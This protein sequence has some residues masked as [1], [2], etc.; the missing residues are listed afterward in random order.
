MGG[1]ESWFIRLLSTAQKVASITT[2]RL[3]NNSCIFYLTCCSSNKNRHVSINII[4][5]HIEISG[6]DGII[7]STLTCR[8]NNTSSNAK[9]G[10]LI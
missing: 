6:K 2:L 7:G 1:N 4:Y 8:P 10:C 3:I 5:Q 9:G